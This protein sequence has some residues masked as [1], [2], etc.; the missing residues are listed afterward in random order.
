M[1]YELPIN[2]PNKIQKVK[3]KHQRV[4]GLQP[5]LEHLQELGE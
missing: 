3:W 4:I 2:S 5:I 1:N